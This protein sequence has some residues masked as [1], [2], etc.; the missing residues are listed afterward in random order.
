M[1]AHRLLVLSIPVVSVLLGCG[2]ENATSEGASTPIASSLGP[3]PAPPTAANDPTVP[4]AERHPDS[5]KVSWKQDSPPKRCHLTPASGELVAAVTEIASK[6]VD[7]TKMHMLG[8]VTQGEGRE[9]D[10]HKDPM[11][12]RVPLKA[13]ANHCYRI[14]GLA[15]PGVKDFD[16][17][18]MDSTGKSAGEDLTDSNDA[19][20]LEDGSICFKQDDAA[21]VNVAVAKGSGK[22]AVEIWGD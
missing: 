20:V 16:I 18:V 14:F 19:I 5:D 22:W 21:S 15:E 17:A 11:V 12:T 2:G 9:G 3:N 1:G 4:K 6:C 7:A 13:Q 8:S 10:Q